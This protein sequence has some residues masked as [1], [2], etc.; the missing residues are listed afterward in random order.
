MDS[1]ALKNLQAP[2]KEKYR[3]EPASAIITLKAHGNI[4][5]GISCKIETGHAMVEAGLH[6]ATGGTGLLVC[7]GDLLLEALVACAGVTLQAV[8]TAIG[9]D[10][11]NG[12]VRAEGDLDFRGTLGVSK[13]VPVGFTSIRLAFDLETNATAEQ[14]ESLKKLTERYCVVYQTLTKGVS[15][16]TEF[17]TSQ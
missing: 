15:V 13:E 16:E 1:I 11:K 2:L 3:L 9:I 10:L 5:E 12:V 14:I 4:G 17:H 8:A 7:S 6:P